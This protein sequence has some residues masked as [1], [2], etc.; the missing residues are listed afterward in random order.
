MV[1]SQLI[2]LSTVD[3]K[4]R[5]ICVDGSV[6]MLCLEYFD[7]VVREWARLGDD[8]WL[9]G[10]V[11]RFLG[12]LIFSHGRMTVTIEVAEIALAMVTRQIDLALMVLAETY[13]KLDRISYR[14]HH[15]HSC[16]ALV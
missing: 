12:E 9:R 10:F 5:L 8:L 2:G 7:Q 11:T 16:G 14:C 6:P 4:Q 15:F 3:C 13:R 1:L